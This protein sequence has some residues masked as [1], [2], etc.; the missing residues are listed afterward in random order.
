[1]L[2]TIG[3]KSLLTSNENKKIVTKKQRKLKN[4][5]IKK[6]KEKRERFKVKIENCVKCIKRYLLKFKWDEKFFNKKDKT[7]RNNRVIKIKRTDRK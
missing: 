1:M 7:K 6:E 5:R 3:N 2:V 4:R